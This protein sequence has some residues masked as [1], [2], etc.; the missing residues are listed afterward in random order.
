MNRINT[1]FITSVNAS[2]NYREKVNVGFYIE[3]KLH[4]ANTSNRL[5]EGALKILGH[6]KTRAEAAGCRASSTDSSERINLCF[7]FA[8]FYVHS[9]MR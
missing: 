7:K 9:A 6:F 4:F 5:S 1:I 2:D 3:A 8:S